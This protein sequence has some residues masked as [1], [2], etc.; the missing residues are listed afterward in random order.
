MHPAMH[1]LAALGWLSL[2]A[3][4]GCDALAQAN[5]S[6]GAPQRAGPTA[7]SVFTLAR[8][9]VETAEVDSS[10]TPDEIKNEALRL[11][12]RNQLASSIRKAG[13]ESAFG[14]YVATAVSAWDF[15]D[16]QRDTAARQA[17]RLIQAIER[18]AKAMF[19]A[20]DAEG[21]GTLLARRYCFGSGRLTG[22]FLF[23]AFC[24]PAD[25]LMLG[26]ELDAGRL[27]AA[28]RRLSDT[29]WKYANEVLLAE[30]VARSFIAAGRADEG[31]AVLAALRSKRSITPVSI[32]EAYWRLGA[33]E[34]G[35]RSMRE[36]AA[37]ALDDARSDPG[38]GLP[39]MLPGVQIAMGDRDGALRTLAQI[40]GFDSRRLNPLRAPLAGQLAFA[41]LDADAFVLAS[42]APADREVLSNIAVGQARRGD[43]AAAFATVR[44][45]QAT[46]GPEDR[47]QNS[48]LRMAVTSI[49]RN[50]ARAG[51]TAAFTQANAMRRTPDGVVH[52]VTA[53]AFGEAA[54]FPR[55]TAD[56]RSLGDLARAGQGRFAVDHAL[57]LPTLATQL[58]GLESVGEALSGLPNPFYN[59]LAFYDPI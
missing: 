32:A 7:V 53:T 37:A 18:L 45:L 28:A 17:A 8:Q 43:F 56:T 12:L 49:V 27:A 33:I 4:G 23:V 1:A 38:R 6:A 10:R 41:G 55:D 59:P 35:R 34:E 16:P 46:E 57:A 22:S 40:R 20:G 36:A 58:S 14:D 19:V 39:V 13:L 5:Q 29:N 3:L 54:Q 9:L 21:A 52:V 31:Y 44:K 15:W 26:W 51:D 2:A 25:E 30:R 42:A 50:A 47:L 24:A 11:P 48:A